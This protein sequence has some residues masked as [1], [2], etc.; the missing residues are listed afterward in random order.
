MILHKIN[1]VK[2][3]IMDKNVNTIK[4]KYSIHGLKTALHVT[5][6]PARAKKYHNMSLEWR[7]CQ[8]FALSKIFSILLPNN[9]QGQGGIE[10]KHYTVG[11]LKR[12][13][14]NID[15]NVSSDVAFLRVSGSAFH[16]LGAAAVKARSP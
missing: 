16:N 12:C 7:G 5:L 14:L 3:V 15:L 8:H 1:S 6:C 10:L 9:K 4:Y 2:K 11:F 13:V